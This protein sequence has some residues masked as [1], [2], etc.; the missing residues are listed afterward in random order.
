MAEETVLPHPNLALPQHY[1]VLS[2]P[3]LSHLH[4][5]ARTSL[6]DGIKADEM[7]PYYRIVTGSGALS[8]DGKLLEEMD[9]KN[10]EELES[11]EKRIEE[12]KATEGET[13]VAE[14]LRAKAAYLTRIG[15][16]V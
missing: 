4:S 7:A 16:K 5:S 9:K 8:L 3:S 15:E 12:A 11:L 10:K 13:D 6:L 2:K 1:F 14:L